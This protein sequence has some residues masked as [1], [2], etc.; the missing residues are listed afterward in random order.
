[1]FSWTVSLKQERSAAW[2]SA[3]AIVA[4][5]LIVWGFIEAIYALSIV[6]IILVGVFFLVENN[7][8][9]HVEITVDDNGIGVGPEFY[10]YPKISNFGIIY[11]QGK[12]VLLRLQLHV[13][14]I[15]T[16]DVDL[17]AGA[18]NAAELRAFLSQ[19]A[20]ESKD[21]ELGATERITRM[22]GL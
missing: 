6:V 18:V 16:L 19:Y 3:A 17:P 11:D 1:M 13:R 21:A 12:P 5:S 10:D 22:L 20:E 8:P 9:E 7:A 2:Y 4:A 14:G 15:K